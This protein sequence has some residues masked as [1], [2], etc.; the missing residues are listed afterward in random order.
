[1]S[2]SGPA[3]M[4]RVR[5]LSRLPYGEAWDLQRA[6][7]ER[8]SGGTIVE[9]YLFL[10]EHPHVDTGGRR[11]DGSHLLISPERLAEVGAEF[12]RVDRG[13][14]ITYHGPGQLVGY[15]LVGVRPRR[16]TD[17]VR[18]LEEALMLTL[19]DLGVGSW[20]ERGLTGVW[21]ERGKVAAIGV[22]VSRRVSMHGFALNLHPQM[23]YFGYINQ[24]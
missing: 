11:G 10:L 3:P 23:D 17:Y 7:W 6:V 16:V 19:S 4:L 1:M 8:R 13:G 21:T 12:F 2:D 14:D 20:R 5:W 15:P 18:S 9:D 24:E 22:R